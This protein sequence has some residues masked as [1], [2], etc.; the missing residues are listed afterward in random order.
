ME[1]APWEKTLPYYL[2]HDI[3]ALVEIEKQDPLPLSWDLY[4]NELQGSINSA[5]W[6]NEIS[7]EQAQYLRE[8]YL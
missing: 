3:E 5:F 2:R 7:A 6:D 1:I 8:K 4:Y